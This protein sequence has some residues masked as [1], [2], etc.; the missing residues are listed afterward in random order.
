MFLGRMPVIILRLCMADITA[1]GISHNLSFWFGQIMYL[2]AF[3][4]RHW[5]LSLGPLN[6][7]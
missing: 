4:G 7:K 2:H 1:Y 3:E 6:V 5:V